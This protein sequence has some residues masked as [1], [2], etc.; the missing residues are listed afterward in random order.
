MHLAVVLD[1]FL[2]RGTGLY[3]L[4]RDRSLS[5]P[6]PKLRPRGNLTSNFSDQR[7]LFVILVEYTN[8]PCPT[9]HS[10]MCVFGFGLTL[11][12]YRVPGTTLSQ[13]Q[14]KYI[15]ISIYMVT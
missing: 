10:S 15:Y 3:H 12:G 5:L 13:P 7:S 2:L 4:S 8:P 6:N 1:V 9:T 11:P 14:R